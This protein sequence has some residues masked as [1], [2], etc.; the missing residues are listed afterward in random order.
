MH[1]I[2]GLELGLVEHIPIWGN[3]E[4]EVLR[5][6]FNMIEGL[7]ILRN[8]LEEKTDLK[9]KQINKWIQG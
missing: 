8:V 7:L 3:Y 2:T 5:D 1:V 4:K 6:L 9:G